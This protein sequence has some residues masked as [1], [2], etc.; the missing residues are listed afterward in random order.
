MVTKAQDH[1][2]VNRNRFRLIVLDVGFLVVKE[3]Q[4]PCKDTKKSAPEF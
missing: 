4:R 1:N 2:I 3:A